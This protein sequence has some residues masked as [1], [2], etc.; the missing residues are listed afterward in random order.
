[1]APALGLSISQDIIRSHKGTI[2]VESVLGKGNDLY[3]STADGQSSRQLQWP[4]DGHRPMEFLD[5]VYKR[6]DAMVFP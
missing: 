5:K 3:H 4:G 2:Q 6:D 1:M